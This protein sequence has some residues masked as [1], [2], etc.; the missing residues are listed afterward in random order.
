M[1]K[2]ILATMLILPVLVLL[3]LGY[4]RLK[5]RQLPENT[6]WDGLV[7]EAT[8][9][10]VD[11]RPLE[12]LLAWWQLPDQHPM[13]AMLD[14]HNTW[15]TQRWN[16]WLLKAQQDAGAGDWIKS[17]TMMG[18]RCSDTLVLVFEPG[19][20]WPAHRVLEAV[21]HW[22]DLPDWHPATDTAGMCPFPWE[23][24]WWLAQARHRWVVSKSRRLARMVQKRFASPSEKS[25]PIRNLLLSQN[26]PYDVMWAKKGGEGW[27]A[28][29]L[30]WEP[31]SVVWEGLAQAPPQGLGKSAS[32]NLSLLAALEPALVKGQEWQVDAL[33]ITLPYD[34][35]KT[36]TLSPTSLALATVHTALCSAADTVTVGWLGG[37]DLAPPSHLMPVQGGGFLL[38]EAWSI[39]QLGKRAWKAFR[40][41]EN[42]WMLVA[43]PEHLGWLPSALPETKGR[44]AALCSVQPVLG[45]YRKKVEGRCTSNLFSFTEH[46]EIESP[47]ESLPVFRFR[48][49]EADS[50]LAEALPLLNTDSFP[51]LLTLEAGKNLKALD[52]K[53]NLAWEHT[54][55][56]ATWPGIY[57]MASKTDRYR[58]LIM[59]ADKL[60]ALTP[61]GK[62]ARNFPVSLP[63]PPISPFTAVG[64]ASTLT[65]R[66]ALP[67]QTGLVLNY[68]SAGEPVPDWKSNLPVGA[69]L[70]RV[71]S[72]Q[73]GE[74]RAYWVVCTDGSLV[75]K[76][77][78]GKTKRKATLPEGGL[79]AV[80]APDAS[81][82]WLQ[83]GNSLYK[84]SLN[85]VDSIDKPMPPGKLVA[86]WHSGKAD[87]LA[88]RAGNRTHLFAPEGKSAPTPW[89]EDFY[90]FNLYPMPQGGVVAV[91]KT[92][93][94]LAPDKGQPKWLNVQDVR[95]ICFT[96]SGMGPAL[97]WIIGKEAKG[98][99]LGG[100]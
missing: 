53:G 95:T 60:H 24:G 41:T 88:F 7:P 33:T 52:A 65:Y 46:Y 68:Q 19:A 77:K 26:N 81:H 72:V 78:K 48:M 13:R 28:G 82:W 38:P 62:E 67:T 14:A 59:E 71:M 11:P 56:Q 18:M 80:Q 79:Y 51:V 20:N 36:L 21:Q 23:K 9:A 83:K 37:K 43:E 8:Q 74:D 47:R 98:Y 70:H 25:S 91:D 10:W 2:R 63:E 27:K 31:N 57:P 99:V 90:P 96:P 73:Q 58:L 4:L 84:L 45:G 15:S 61:K 30:K 64:D 85:Q 5:E 100:R 17:L 75:R 29:S 1:T 12:H 87:V 50:L 94:L 44:R 89:P 49:P 93:V 69:D 34:S 97:I 35:G 86:V 3:V 66:I 22:V 42:G 76:N 32:G 54:F 6:L 16:E 39:P 92:R 40:A 55:A